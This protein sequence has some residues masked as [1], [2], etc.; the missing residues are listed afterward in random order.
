MSEAINQLASHQTAGISRLALTHSSLS[1]TIFVL[2]FASTVAFAV[3][4][5]LAYHY[6]VYRE[7]GSIENYAAVGSLAGLGYG[8]AFLIRDEYGVESLLR[9]RRSPGRMFLVWNL[10]FIG[11]AVIGFLTKSTQM[12]SRG[13]LLLFYVFGFA[14]A[15]LINS[16]T[17][18]GLIKLMATGWLL[19]RKLMLVASVRDFALIEQGVAMGPGGYHIVARVPLPHPCESEADVEEALAAAVQNARALG[20]EDI[21]VSSELGNHEFLERT[22]NALS[23]LPIGI[24]LSALGIVGRF[25]DARVARFGEVAALS[26]TR[27]PLGPFEAMAKRWFDLVVSAITLLLLAP[28]FAVIALAIKHESKGPV[29]FRQ[30]RRGYNTAEF[31]IWKFRTMTTLE[32]GDVIEQVKQ[33]DGRVTTVGR[34]LRRTSLDELPQLVNVLMGEMSLVGPRPHAVA[35]DRSFEKRIADYPRRL[36]VKP[37]ITGWAQVNGFR[38]ATM[39]D[40]AMRQRVDHDLFYIDN[41]SLGFDL[42]ILLLTV[43]SPK[44]S[45][46]AH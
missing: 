31:K 25:K 19:R 33:N 1:A 39:T 26:L 20:I 5:G 11:M 34:L 36:N 16:V 2:E 24:H 35:H 7:V 44:T 43:I 37:G 17:Q 14:A 22:V 3:S 32:D 40:E 13:W 27:A 8:L 30:R 29:F 9:G 12:F 28:L 10:V 46:N 4:T 45:R 23:V 6:I 15:L 41:C 18:R 21:I 42:Y 38:G